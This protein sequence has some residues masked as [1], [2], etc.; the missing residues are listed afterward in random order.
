[1]NGLLLPIV[2]V[3]ILKLAGDRGLM[4]ENANTRVSQWI[5]VGTA[6]GASALSV[7][8]VAV[9]LLGAG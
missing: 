7:A 2:L 3:F 5:G 4:G 6:I 8:L 1:V 9:T